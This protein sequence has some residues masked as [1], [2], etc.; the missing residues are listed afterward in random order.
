MSEIAMPF[1]RLWNYVDQTGG[2]PGKMLF[3]CAVIMLVIG[4]LTWYGNKR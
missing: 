1:V 3:I 4:A 2:Y